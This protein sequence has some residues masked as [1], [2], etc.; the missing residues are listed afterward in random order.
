MTLVS[1]LA[2]P[3][4]VAAIALLAA[5]LLPVL[6]PTALAEEGGA[7]GQEGQLVV[8]ELKPLWTLALDY[9]VTRLVWSESGKYL[10]IGTVGG[11]MLVDM[12]GNR[13]WG[14]AIGEPVYDAAF[15]PDDRLVA[16]VA[17]KIWHYVYVL[18][19]T[20]GKEVT[21]TSS[22]QGDLVSTGWAAS[23][24]LVAG[25]SREARL[26][27]YEWMKGV[28]GAMELR[29]VDKITLAGSDGKPYEGI[30]EIIQVPD[31]ERVLVG[32]RDGHV[33][34]VSIIA[35]KPVWTTVDLGDELVDLALGREVAAAAVV[36][37]GQGVTKLYLISV[38]DG[39]VLSFY[40]LDTMVTSIAVVGS[41]LIAA[42]ANGNLYLF[43]YSRGSLALFGIT[44][45]TLASITDM[46]IS[47]DGSQL[48]IGT[49][50]GFVMAFS[51]AD[52]IYTQLVKA[53]SGIG[54]IYT[55]VEISMDGRPVAS[56]RTTIDVPS[57]MSLNIG[58]YDIA[59][60]ATL[61]YT[62]VP[63]NVV[64][65]VNV[66]DLKDVDSNTTIATIVL[67]E[68]LEITC[69]G[70]AY[71]ALESNVSIRGRATLGLSE[72]GCLELLG[73]QDRT[74]VRLRAVPY[75]SI[76]YGGQEGRTTSE[77]RVDNLVAAG[78]VI[79]K[80]FK[81]EQKVVT[82]VLVKTVTVTREVT[83]TETLERVE[84][85]TVTKEC[86]VTAASG[87]GGATSAAQAG[88]V[89]TGAGLA[90]TAAGKPLLG[91]RSAIAAL[92]VALIAVG[93][94]MLLSRQGVA[95][96]RKKE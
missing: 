32:T 87:V 21:R 68:P 83:V 85:V 25:E 45:V 89:A 79:A 55:R 84:T 18:D 80:F 16:V 15:S 11:A 23:R 67:D 51:A 82:P 52:L 29:Q 19:T 46:A 75:I 44:R 70:I 27:V 91:S 66:I 6:P 12:D 40:N 13:K 86:N 47:P 31:T 94:L 22:L 56:F 37:R 9:G 72:K 8:G 42:D 10:L 74:L 4:V 20:S 76:Y 71:G 57:I 58:R 95:A 73:D 3:S 88:A 26:Y 53:V 35:G 77:I 43:Q 1:R 30:V 63:C 49:E 36:D 92:V 65:E 33:A 93:G 78:V 69:H 39:T 48:V 61:E 81:P 62:R 64:L 5:V 90:S 50:K 41:Y 7:A 59:F 34:L 2:S 14:L 96:R 54:S 38:R 17:G 60:E 28:T 24:F